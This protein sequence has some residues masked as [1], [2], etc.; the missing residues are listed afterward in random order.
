MAGD[1][2]SSSAAQPARG[3]TASPAST[4][5][6]A[7]NAAHQAVPMQSDTSAAGSS[8]SAAPVNP[9]LEEELHLSE[10]F[11]F[12]RDFLKAVEEK[13][14]YTQKTKEEIIAVKKQMEEVF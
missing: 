11:S 3:D 7:D 6:A 1:Q 4:S 10:N 8:N 2:R 13:E 12:I 5:S 9:V 14:D